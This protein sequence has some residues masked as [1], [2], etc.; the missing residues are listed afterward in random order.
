MFT[1]P[2]LLLFIAIVLL[3]NRLRTLERSISD[4]EP[5]EINIQPKWDKLFKDYNLVNA[6]WNMDKICD[7]IKEEKWHVLKDGVRFTL[8]KPDLIYYNDLNIFRTEV[9]FQPRIRELNPNFADFIGFRVKWGGDGF[10]IFL[11][12]PESRQKN[13]NYPPGYDPDEIKIATIPYSELRMYKYKNAKKEIKDQIL[14]DYEWTREEHPHFA[15][16]DPTVTL[17]HKYFTVYYQYI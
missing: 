17:E 15:F 3:F 13:P 12:T 7:K 10:E 8:L 16:I 9:H 4:F 5:I 6:D 14:R 2:I 1:W 11:S